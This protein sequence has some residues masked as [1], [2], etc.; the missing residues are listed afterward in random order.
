MIYSVYVDGISIYDEDPENALIEPNSETELNAAGSFEF[1]LPY[2]HRYYDLPKPL[3]SDVEI[4]ENNQII[5]FG[6]I[7]EIEIDW[8]NQKKVY[9]EGALGYFN[10]SIQRPKEYDDGDQSIKTFFRDLIDR[11]NEQVPANRKFVVGEINIDEKFIYR[12]L[13]YENTLDCLEDMCVN[14]EGGYL[15]TRKENDINYIDWLKEV[16]YVGNQPLQYGLNLTELDQTLDYSELF[17]SIIP[18]GEEDEV[19]GVRATCADENNGLDYIDS[20]L[21][22]LYGRITKVVEFDGLTQPI[23]LKEAG[24][25]YILDHQFEPL[26]IET[27]AAE[28]AYLNPDYS[29]FK[30]GMMVQVTSTPHFIDTQFPILKMGL[31][32]D[33]GEKNITIGTVKKKTL[34][35]IYKEE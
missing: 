33:S 19:T 21:V 26:T 3:I 30:V 16:P 20:D 13:D 5:W 32:L 7:T 1:T 4:R 17:T 35:E 2:S 12:K 34:T 15:I 9:C 14:A 28:L 29:V 10:D 18:L 24:D 6:R 27:S 22:K 11:H 31:S 23:D 8:Y 25:K